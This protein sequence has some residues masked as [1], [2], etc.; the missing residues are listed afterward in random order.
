MKREVLNTLLACRSDK[1]S[2]ALITNIESGLQ[3]LVY[4]DRA[5]YKCDQQQI[6][7]EAEIVDAAHRLLGEQR[8][9]AV[10]I[11][12]SRFLIRAYVPAPRL[13]VVGAVHIAQALLPMAELAG[14]QVH[15]IDPREAFG[16]D[17]R[18]PGIDVIRQWPDQACESLSPD[19]STAVVTLSH[20]PKID[21]PALQIALASE[22][23]YVGALGSRKTHAARMERLSALGID[24]E[25]LT[26]I[27]APIGLALGG[28]EPAEIA[29]S[30]LAQIIETRYQRQA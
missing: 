26:R 19:S 4:A 13:I 9:A 21:E 16:A 25:V 5:I 17:N 11:A 6:G 28:R 30:I 2:A 27:H 3:C 18:F 20:D 24:A 15:L 7:P 22:A 29:V 23:F 1:R 8:S 14:F 10:E 12:D